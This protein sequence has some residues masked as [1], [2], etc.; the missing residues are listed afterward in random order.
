M[1]KSRWRS[2]LV[3]SK[4]LMPFTK[5]FLEVEF[6]IDAS[7]FPLHFNGNIFLCF[8]FR[9]RWRRRKERKPKKVRQK[10]LSNI[11]EKK[12]FNKKREKLFSLSLMKWMSQKEPLKLFFAFLSLH[13]HYYYYHAHTTLLWLLLLFA[14]NDKLL[15]SSFLFNYI[16]IYLFQKLICCLKQTILWLLEFNLTALPNQLTL[17]LWQFLLLSFSF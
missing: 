13:F 3:I 12:N 2:S 14:S 6:V 15:F 17:E 9:T 10:M 5:Y 8:I 11:R 1:Q 7:L 4:K 16:I